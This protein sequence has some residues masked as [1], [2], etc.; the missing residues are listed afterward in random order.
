[1][2]QKKNTCYVCVVFEYRFVKNKTF[3]FSVLKNKYNNAQKTI[4]ETEFTT[5]P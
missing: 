4:V 5:P 3:S 1:M 2:Y